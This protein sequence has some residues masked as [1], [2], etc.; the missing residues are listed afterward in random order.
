MS[1]R[2]RVVALVVALL[3]VIGVAVIALGIGARGD[4]VGADPSAAASP[5]AG[6]PTASPSV[7]A[8]PSDAPSASADDGVVA[9]LREI[10]QQVIE[11]RG[12][13]AAEIGP[14]EI[15]TRDELEDELIRIFEEDYPEEEQERDNV[16]LRALGLLEP[17]Q[18]VA[19]LQL[20]LLG[21]QVLG[22]YDDVDKRMVV[23]SDAGLDP[24]AK[25]TYAHEYAH[26]LQDAAFGLDSLE[27]DAP[28]EDDRALAR[29]ALIEG[30]A[31]VVMLAWAFAHLSQEEL[32]QVGTG[33]PLPDTTGIPSWMVDSLEFPY[34][35]GLEWAT[36]LAG[37]SFSPDFTELDAAYNDPPNTTE[38]IIDLS[39]WL[40][41]EEA[42]EIETVDLAAALGDGWEEVDET[43]IGQATIRMMLEFFGVAAETAVTAADGWGGD[44]AVIVSGPDDA[45]AVAWRL[46]WD[47]PG[48]A[49]EFVAAYQQ[50]I[51]A[52]D[53]PA[54]V[55]ELPGEEVLV[56]HASSEELLS[57]TLA[58]AR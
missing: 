24:A 27:R 38:Q 1:S 20:Q 11:I 6:E 56:V 35:E 51:D 49:D 50:A 16:A 57:Q 44:R 32:I 33:T 13:P 25:L 42:E 45:F 17:G 15:I 31:S 36:A 40:R 48:D 4:G 21:D 30:D 41:R 58:A 2:E 28:G 19:E 18:D 52:L 29:T 14:P 8:S 53:F 47:A 10:E 34:T 7:S 23:V 55:E 9:A 39:A 37:E 22:F 43:P 26:A 54:T 3:V 12:L 46:A 5:S